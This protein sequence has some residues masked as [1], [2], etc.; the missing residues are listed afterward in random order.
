MN[1]ISMLHQIAEMSAIQQLRTS[2]SEQTSPFQSFFSSFMKEELGKL[3]G[4]QQA[5]TRNMSLFL[6]PSLQL[7][8]EQQLKAT[9]VGQTPALSKK[10][11]S[12]YDD[13]IQA[14]AK[15]YG[16]DPNLISA[17]IKQ[18][19][20]FNPNA[21][22]HAGAAGLMQLMPGTAR[23]LGVTNVYDPAQNIEGGTKY[24]RQMMDKYNGDV[25][26]ALAAYNAG[27]GNVDKYGG[28]PPFRETQK[29]VPAVL[30]NFMK[31]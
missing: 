19:S 10:N 9:V 26:L 27:P 15:K 8:T 6:H 31:A 25:R 22:S 13:L 23:F 24:L 16:V 5:P 1:N 28:I 7:E 3:S 2:R 11:P 4:I 12:Q 30:Q 20:N 29:Y 21:K 17:V 18:E 14:A